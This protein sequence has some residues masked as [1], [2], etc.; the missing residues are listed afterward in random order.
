M[1]NRQPF[2]KGKFNASALRDRSVYFNGSAN[3]SLEAI[4]DVIAVRAL[5]GSARISLCVDGSINYV[6]T[7]RGGA[8]ISIL[9]DGKINA[10]S[11]FTGR[12][13]VGVCTSGSVIRACELGVF[14]EI[15]ANGGF[16]KLLFNR[17]KFNIAS[18]RNYKN[19]NA[20]IDINVTGQMSTFS[21]FKGN[22]DLSLITSGRLN[23][24][25]AYEGKAEAV[26][27][28]GGAI[29]IIKPLYGDALMRL[30]TSSA[31]FTR[32]RIFNGNK[33]FILE[34]TSKSFNTYR[35]EYIK[36]PDLVMK[37]GDELVINTDEMTVT[38]NGQNVIKYLSR[39][40]EFFLFNP[41][42]NDIIYK[43]GNTSDKVDIKILW[44]DAY[45]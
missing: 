4:G 8:D 6:R 43:S 21:I 10:V 2:N 37:T 18:F 32:Q 7:L 9:A 17:G 16:N 14:Y 3:I 5:V 42:E 28:T 20:K 45:L 19:C 26:L 27:T 30:E 11:G 36:L 34:V 33:F 31:L 24:T 29:G 22:I 39:D 1:F 15:A 35:Y 25:L 12:A 41:H 40:S 44:K 38:L 23:A 13:A